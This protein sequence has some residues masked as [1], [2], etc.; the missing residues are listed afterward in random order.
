MHLRSVINHLSTSQT[1]ELSTLLYMENNF[2]F[3][4]QM[5]HIILIGVLIQ[6]FFPPLFYFPGLQSSSHMQSREH[7]TH[8]RRSYTFI[9]YSAYANRRNE[10][11]CST[12]M[13][14]Y[15]P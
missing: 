3:L 14:T 9:Y 11:Q 4:Q 15:I 13:L 10:E 1:A 6:T 5:Q 8:K 12:Q 2:A 7:Q